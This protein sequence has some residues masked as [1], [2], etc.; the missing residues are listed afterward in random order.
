MTWGNQQQPA[1]GNFDALLGGGVTPSASFKGQFPIRWEGVVEDVTKNPAYE[2]DPSKPNNRG[3]QKFWPDGNP[4]ENLWITLQTEVRDPNVQNDTGRRVLVLDSKNKLTAVQDAVRDSGAPFAK[5]GRLVIEWYGNDTAN[6][7][8]PDNPPKLYRAQ[9]TG[10]TFDGALGS[11]GQA[12][13]QQAPAQYSPVQAQQTGSGWGQQAAQQNTAAAGWGAPA[14]PAAP[15][16]AWGQQAPAQEAPSVW[17]QP[18][19]Q[20]P[21]APQPLPADP[22]QAMAAIAR[23]GYDV[24]QITSQQQAEQIWAMI[25]H[26]PDV[27]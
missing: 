27:A 8:N 1:T 7:K 13:Q 12:P 15:A 4:V 9:Y 17:G 19:P 20:A 11:A 24:S 25:Q 3:A 21:P 16:N 10:P 23:K 18:A 22:Q 14:Q 2:Y 5:G 6:A 26:Q